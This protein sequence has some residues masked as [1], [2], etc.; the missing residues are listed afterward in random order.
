M[1][2]SRQPPVERPRQRGQPSAVSGDLDRRGTSAFGAAGGVAA[3]DPRPGSGGR[4]PAGLDSRSVHG[5]GPRRRRRIHRAG[6]QRARDV[7]RHRARRHPRGEEAERRRVHLRDRAV[8]DRLHRA[9]AAR[10]RGGRAG[11][12]AARGLHRPAVHPGR[13]RPDQRQEVQQPGSRQ[14][15]RRAA[16][17]DQGRDRRRLLQHRHRHVDARR[18]DEGDAA[19]SSRK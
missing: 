3:P 9:A 19:T 8:G 13:P 17:A 10:V 14:G 2:S 15:A 12:G 16:R 4:H 6:D 7:L 5:D 18:P 11:R 1:P